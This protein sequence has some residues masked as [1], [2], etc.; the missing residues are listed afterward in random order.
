MINATKT[1]GDSLARHRFDEEGKGS[2]TYFVDASV[3]CVW[4]IG[5]GLLGPEPIFSILRRQVLSGGY[6]RFSS[7]VE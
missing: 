6:G 5:T 1:R 2:A 4:A 3:L 7:S